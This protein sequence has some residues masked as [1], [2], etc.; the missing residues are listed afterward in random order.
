MY[1]VQYF[2]FIASR[3]LKYLVKFLVYLLILGLVFIAVLLL[4]LSLF[5]I[6]WTSRQWIDELL[7]SLGLA[8]SS[9]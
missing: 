8:T 6:L 1:Y 5:A 2:Y 4:S 9:L 7:R 3:V